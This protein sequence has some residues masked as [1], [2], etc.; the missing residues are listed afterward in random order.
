MPVALLGLLCAIRWVPDSSDPDAKRSDSLGSL[1]SITGLGLLLWAIIEAPVRGWSSA[2]VLGGGGGGL[3]MLG[4]F[5]AW[6]RTSSHP[7]LELRYF[8]SGRFSAA[9]LC[10]GLLAFG[11]YGALFVLTQLLQFQLGYSPLQA[12]VRVLPA[13]GAIAVMAPLSTAL[14]KRLGAKLT[15]AAGLILVAGGLW[16]VSGATVAT[17]YG[18]TVAGMVL[19]GI[20]AGLAIPPSTG[21]VMGSLPSAHTGVGSA[22]NGSFMQV[23][24]ALGV[25]IVG[26]LLST[27]YQDRITSA[28]APYQIPHAIQETIRG[29]L[30]GALGVA[31]KV[32]GVTGVFLA[33]FAHSAFISG[34]DLGLLVGALVALGGAVVALLA[35]PSRGGPEDGPLSGAGRS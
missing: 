7:M 18:G 33:R 5:I 22:T 8:R 31:E 4:G 34:M 1:L 32:G 3:A 16:Q 25:A 26:S 6:E 15:V 21:A 27:R 24:G 11:L 2:L 12:G 17:T 14:V 30:G 20:G 19:L 23:G 9:V 28:I 29:S 13:A 10:N 35:L